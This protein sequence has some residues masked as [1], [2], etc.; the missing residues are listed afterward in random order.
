MV[1][2]F[3]KFFPNVLAPPRKDKIQS[4]ERELDNSDEGKKGAKLRMRDDEKEKGGAKEKISEKV[5]DGE[6]GGEAGGEIEEEEEYGEEESLNDMNYDQALEKENRSF[7]TVLGQLIVEKVDILSAIFTKS[8]FY[9]VPIRVM[10]ILFIFICFFFSNALFLN[11]DCIEEIFN[12]RENFDFISI[13]SNNIAV[14]VESAAIMVVASKFFSLLLSVGATF[15]YF[16]RTRLE[17]KEEREKRIKKREMIKRIKELRNEIRSIYRSRNSFKDDTDILGK[18]SNYL[19][20]LDNINLEMDSDEEEDE[21]E[22]RADGNR[23]KGFE[24]AY[25]LRELIKG[26]KIKFGICFI[27]IIVLGAVFLYF[28]MA[29]GNV[30]RKMQ[31]IWIALVVIGVIVQILLYIAISLLITIFRFIGLKYHNE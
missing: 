15:D 31:G 11:E 14:T 18:E 13:I 27:I 4:S 10:V 29:F 17:R 30:Y 22:E 16:M 9:P 21:E 12:L 23:Q 5:Q 24:D 28:L 26:V 19:S 3:K 1:D 7:G 8:V 6:E 25:R 2:E 20:E